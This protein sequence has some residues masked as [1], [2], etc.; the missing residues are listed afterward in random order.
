MMGVGAGLWVDDEVEEDSVV[1]VAATVT[2]DEDPVA[3][4]VA[5]VTDVVLL[6]RT[7]PSPPQDTSM[8]AIASTLADRTGDDTMR[9]LDM[10]QFVARLHYRRVSANGKQRRNPRMP[11]MVGLF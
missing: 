3:L 8:K 4:S 6:D 2:G 1:G 7:S 10:G 11:I 5:P 9:S